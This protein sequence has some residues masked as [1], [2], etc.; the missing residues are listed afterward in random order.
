[1]PEAPAVPVSARTYPKS[2][3]WLT[4]AGPLS[5]PIRPRIHY[6]HGARHRDI[7]P[8]SQYRLRV[9]MGL[10]TNPTDQHK[11]QWRTSL[12]G[13]LLGCCWRLG[14]LSS[15]HLIFYERSGVAAYLR[16]DPIDCQPLP[17]LCSSNPSR[18]PSSV[19]CS[20]SCMARW[21]PVW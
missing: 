16:I 5:K 4:M 8:P 11:C 3:H 21:W 6:N 2:L 17:I 20:Q 12:R 13:S 7:P 18:H 10:N 14:P 15:L 19:S 9:F 1:M